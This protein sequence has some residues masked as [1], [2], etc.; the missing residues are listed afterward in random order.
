MAKRYWLLKSEPNVFSI[1]DLKK[2][3]KRTTEWEGVRNYQ[4]RN[5]LRDEIQVG[6]E[7][8]FYHSRV[9]PM[10]VVGTATVVRAGYPDDTQ[11]DPRSKYYDPKATRENP[12]WYRIDIRFET[13]FERP[14]TLE[15]MKRIPAL[16]N[17]VLLNR[18]RLSV[19]PVRPSEWKAILK[20]GLP[21]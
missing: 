20:R 21:K 13:Q 17:M 4:A 9:E 6:D 10:A 12:R 11:F 15:E 8:L 3:P 18:S 1:D 19:Q 16:K 5:L 14:V 2:S 7:V